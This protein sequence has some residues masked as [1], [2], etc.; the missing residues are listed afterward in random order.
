MTDAE[1]GPFNRDTYVYMFPKVV[2]LTAGIRALCVYSD[3]VDLTL[4]GDSKV[5]LLRT[6]PIPRDAKFMDQIDIEFV[7]VHYLPVTRTEIRNIEVYIKDE[8]GEDLEFELGRVILTL[9][10]RK[11]TSPVKGLSNE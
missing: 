2:D 10:F 11:R 3:V 8:S 4:V 1:Y 7:R 6:V 9:H 5:N